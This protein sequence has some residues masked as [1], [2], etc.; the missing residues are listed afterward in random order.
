VMPSDFENFGISIVEAMLSGVPI[1]TTTSTPWS[2]LPAQGAGWWVPANSAAIAK[3]IEEACGLPPEQ[4]AAMGKR[5]KA[6]G[7]RFE[8]R[9]VVGDLLRVYQWMLGRGG[10]P[11]CVRIE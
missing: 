1:I 2:Q 11:D 3:A 7:T 9:Q 8:P 5:A 6:I 10:R 4:R